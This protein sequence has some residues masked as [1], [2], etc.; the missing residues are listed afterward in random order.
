M[1]RRTKS[2]IILLLIFSV[3]SCGLDEEYHLE[4]VPENRV[5]WQSL[6]NA[7]IDLPNLVPTYARGYVIF[8]KIYISELLVDSIQL[9]SH[10]LT[11]INPTLNSD[12]NSIFPST[13]PTVI[14]NTNVSNLFSTRN[15]YQLFYFKNPDSESSLPRNGV[16]IEL[17]FPTNRETPTLTIDPN[18]S[19]PDIYPLYRSLGSVGSFFEAL[20]DRYFINSTS[21][22]EAITNND[23]I[24]TTPPDF[25]NRDVARTNSTNPQTSLFTYVN[26]YVVPV[27][28]D[29]RTFNNIYGKPTHVGIFRLP[30]DS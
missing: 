26:M 30:L 11:L 22:E 5:T 8:Y 24:I 15:Y 19:N 17:F 2:I 23:N 20:P 28:F 10:E 25:K 13:D 7:S 21:G 9:S 4:Q 27:G 16:T 18:S 29:D 6:H 12:Y 14:T 1:K 3:L